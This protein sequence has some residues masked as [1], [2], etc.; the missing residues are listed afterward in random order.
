MQVRACQCGFCRTHAALS[1]TDPRGRL[2]FR[3]VHA[4]ALVRYRFG[5]KLA[6]FLICARCGAY[7]GAL[8]ED[9]VG[10]YGV[11]NINVLAEREQFGAPVRMHYDDETVAARLQR[12]R[13]RWTPAQ[14]EFA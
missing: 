14:L 10:A 12:R 4:E 13:E 11:L 5:L 1:V 6:D 3:V 9:S 7:V 8:M 2:T